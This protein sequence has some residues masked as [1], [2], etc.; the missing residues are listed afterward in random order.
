MRG[1]GSALFAA[2]LL[3]VIGVLDLFY[4]I[5][6]VADSKF[7]VG[8]TH[9]VFSGLH[10]WGWITIGVGA[11]LITGSLS[12]FAGGTYGRVVG[13]VAAT[14]AGIEALFNIGGAH[15]WWSLGVFAVCIVVIHGLAVL[16]EPERA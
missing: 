2:I 16:G 7:Y 14:I 12:L 6:A 1:T 5:A 15:P 4:G 9:Y 8:D 11:I 3:M 13:L 10:T